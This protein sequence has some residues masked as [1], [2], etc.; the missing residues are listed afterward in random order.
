MLQ[1]LTG[2]FKQAVFFFFSPLLTTSVL[3]RGRIFVVPWLIRE[4]GACVP[5]A[6]DVLVPRMNGSVSVGLLLCV[7]SPM[8]L[9]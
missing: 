6:L 3:S 1:G 9:R 5:Q 7:S 8:A 2:S 4:F